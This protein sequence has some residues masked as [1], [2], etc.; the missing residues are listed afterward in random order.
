MPTNGNFVPYN[1]AGF[2]ANLTVGIDTALGNIYPAGATNYGGAAYVRQVPT[3]NVAAVLNS[4]PV[5]LLGFSF[6]VFPGG[7]TTAPSTSP[8][9]TDMVD[10][11]KARLNTDWQFPAPITE[12]LFGPGPLTGQAIPP[13][14][15]PLPNY[16]PSPQPGFFQGPFDAWYGWSMYE[17]TFQGEMHDVPATVTVVSQ[18][19]TYMQ[20]QTPLPGNPPTQ[21]APIPAASLPAFTVVGDYQGTVGTSQYDA[22]LAM[23]PEGDITAVYTNQPLQTS[24][25]VPLD[26][27]GNPTFQN[28]YYR[29][30]DESTNTAGPRV[31]AWTSANGVDLLNP[32]GTATNVN[33]QYMVLTFDEPLTTGDPTVNPDSVYNTAN[34]QIYDSNGNILPKAVAHVDYGLSEVAWMSGNY[35]MDPIPSNK[36]EVILTI[37]GNSAVPGNRP[38]PDGTYTLKVLNAVPASSTTAGQTGI[39]NI[40]GTPLNLTGYNSTGSDFTATITISSSSNP[41]STAASPGLAA[42][43]TP[44]NSTL[45]GQQT[46][47]AVGTQNDL[48]GTAFDQNGNYVIV[49]DSNVTVNNVTT[50]QILGQL[51]NAAGTKKGGQFTIAAGPSLGEP[52][53]AMDA[54][55]DFV[56]TWSGPNPATSAAT[57][58]SDI[59]GRQF[60]PTGKAITRNSR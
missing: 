43:D 39:R 36:W 16:Y 38:L 54:N 59:W 2:L 58:P 45:G 51:Y 37:D 55:G 8:I 57:D 26:P 1:T 17:I 13:G 46:E 50:T 6:P 60:D 23:T 21:P 12:A 4:L 44:I 47:P 30:F 49:W 42:R 20:R 24:G 7:P 10:E 35:G 9:P 32:S 52:D 31:V 3:E 25:A 48:K 19:M 28:I 14:G 22:S 5:A 53:V 41:G 34:Y 33:S 15:G 18:T 56:A 40:Y 27:D 11:V 29:R